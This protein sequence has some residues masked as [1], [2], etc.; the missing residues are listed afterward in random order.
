MSHTRYVAGWIVEA[1]P[2]PE[3]GL[4][5]HHYG[6]SVHTSFEAADTTAEKNGEAYGWFSVEEQEYDPNYY[7]SGEGGWNTVRTWVE[8]QE[9][10][11]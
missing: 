5:T 7:G 6:E 4:L 2:D 3:T 1:F 9:V 11:K 8:G 10:V